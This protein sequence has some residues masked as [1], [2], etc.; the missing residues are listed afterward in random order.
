MD[1]IENQL[2]VLA[3]R[4]AAQETKVEGYAQRLQD[5]VEE[6]KSDS[7]L[8]SLRALLDSAT[9]ILNSLMNEK[10][11]LIHETS[12]LASRANET[13][14]IIT[15]ITQTVITGV[16]Q[17]VKRLLEDSDKSSSISKRSSVSTTSRDPKKQAAFKEKV[18]ARDRKCTLTGSKPKSC[19]AAHIIPWTFHRDNAVLWTQLYQPYCFN[20]L[21]AD[22]DVRN[23]ILLRDDLNGLFDMYLFTISAVDYRVI[24]SVFDERVPPELDNL[25]DKIIKF[26][27]NQNQWPAPE[28]LKHHN[29]IFAFRQEKLKAA[30]EAPFLNRSESG[31]TVTNDKLNVNCNLS[32][33]ADDMWEESQTTSTFMSL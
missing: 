10:V 11:A 4:I 15:G 17:S 16:T 12:A 31:D 19:D 21:D 6:M 27:G 28:F 22:F 1:T 32:K 18:V 26:I 33:L 5:A 20:P 30:A 29:D 9:S 7:V 25:K 3:I 8:A 13:D 2:T 14:K 23:G 24:V